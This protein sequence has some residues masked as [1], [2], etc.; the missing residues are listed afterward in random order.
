MH[1]HQDHVQDVVLGAGQPILH[2]QEKDARTSCAVP[3]MKRSNL[4]N[5]A[6]HG[7]LLAPQT[8]ACLCRSRLWRRGAVFSARP[9]GH[10]FAVLATYLPMR[11]ELHDLG[12]RHD[13]DHGV[14]LARRCSNTSS[15][16]G[17]K[18][19]S[20]NNMVTMTIL[21]WAMSARQC[22][23]GGLGCCANRWRH[24]LS[25]AS[26]ARQGLQRHFLKSARPNGCP[27]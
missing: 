1:Q 5:A 4:G 14:H 9:W 20:M 26:P 6:Q 15:K 27:W 21:A 2:H 8:R 3:G 7:H 13:A 23:N 18:W 11:P 10:R 22:C 16:M 17:R 24:A 19:S 12:C 25:G